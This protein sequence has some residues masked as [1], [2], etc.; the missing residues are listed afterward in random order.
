MRIVWT[1]PKVLLGLEWLSECLKNQWQTQTCSCALRKCV[2]LQ[3]LSGPYAR[4]TK[5]QNP[6]PWILNCKSLTRTGSLRCQ[7][8]R[9]SKQVA[10]SS[11][12]TAV[13]YIS[14]SAG[15]ALVNFPLY[16]V[17]T[18]GIM[19]TDCC[20]YDSCTAYLQGASAKLCQNFG[21]SWSTR[22]LQKVANFG[23]CTNNFWLGKGI[24]CMPVKL[25]RPYP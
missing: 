22:E 9:K 8:T 14:C 19:T 4:N 3:T 25:I 15:S 7:T 6:E 1:K 17:E 23:A 10:R 21:D 24:P 18:A 16:T 5:R 20:P 12:D 11:K 2:R 13:T